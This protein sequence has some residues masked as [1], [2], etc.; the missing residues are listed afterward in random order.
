MH[1]TALARQ[2]EAQ[3]A[4]TARPLNLPTEKQHAERLAGLDQ[5]KF[6]LGKSIAG[7]EQDL[8]GKEGMLAQVREDAGQI[9]SLDETEAFGQDTEVSVLSVACV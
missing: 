3:K 2:F 7:L 1:T 5:Q 9:E 4:A 6:T 8:A